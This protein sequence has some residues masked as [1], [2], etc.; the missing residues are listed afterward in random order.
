MMFQD[1]KNA[2]SLKGCWGGGGGGGGAGG[3]G[4]GALKT[5]AFGLQHLPLDLVNVNA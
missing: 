5:A 1:I 3:V 2:R 4:G